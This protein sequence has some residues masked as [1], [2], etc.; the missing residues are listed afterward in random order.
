MELTSI[1]SGCDIGHRSFGVLLFLRPGSV[2][3]EFEEQE[4]KKYIRAKYESTHK[5]SEFEH[6]KNCDY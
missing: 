2:V 6:N 4:I 5:I 3:W 1:T